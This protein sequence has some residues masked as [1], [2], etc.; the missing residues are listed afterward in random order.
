MTAHGPMTE[1]R[2]REIEANTARAMPDYREG[3]SVYRIVQVTVTDVPALVAE[4]RRLQGAM[5][6]IRRHIAGACGHNK[7]GP[8]L[9]A[10]RDLTFGEPPSTPGGE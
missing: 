7:I 9:K 2:L 5:V 4:V 10:V 1:E 6:E 8:C 3:G